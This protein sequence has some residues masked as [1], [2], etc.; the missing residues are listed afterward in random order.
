MISETKH[1]KLIVGI[2]YGTTYSGISFA[3]SSATDFKDIVS[4]T[5]Y[6]DSC[7]HTAEH[8]EKAP[9]TIAFADENVELLR[10]VWG[11]QVKPRLRSCAWTKLLLDESAQSSYDD[12]NIYH[13]TEAGLMRLPSGRTAE[14]VTA[15][16]F[17]G[18][19]TMFE[20]TTTSMFS[21]VG[22][23][24]LAVEFW[25]TVPASWSERAKLLTK[26]AALRAG[27]GARAGDRIMLISEPEAAA[28]YVLKSG[29]H[30]LQSFVQPKTG[31]MV[32]D[33]GGG[34]VDITTY[35]VTQT[36]PTV[37]LRETVVA[38]K[39]GSSYI[40]RNLHQ[41]LAKRFG[42]AFTSL[43]MD[44][45]GPGSAF[46]DR[47]EAIKKD[48]SGEQP[49]SRL[50]HM[51]YLR[52]P[53]LHQTPETNAYYDNRTSSVLLTH[54][55][56]QL[57]FDPVIASILKL[58]ENQLSAAAKFS[59]PPVS[60]I[61]LVGGFGLSP[62]LRKAISQW[63]AK[64]SIAL[65]T[66]MS[67][68]P[69]ASEIINIH[70]ND[71]SLKVYKEI[72]TKSPVLLARYENSQWMSGD[73]IQL[74]DISCAAGHVVVHYL[75]TDQY[76]PIDDQSTSSEL[77]KAE[78]LDAALT[79]ALQVYR[80]ATKYQLPRL[81]ELASERAKQM[82]A[83]LDLLALLQIVEGEFPGIGFIDDWIATY[84]ATRIRSEFQAL[85]HESATLLL[86]DIGRIESLNGI[87]I[88]CMLQLWREKMHLFDDS[89]AEDSPSTISN[90]DVCETSADRSECFTLESAEFS[91][92]SDAVAL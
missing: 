92:G 13:S 24:E 34:T 68:G 70:F 23:D 4:W 36:E 19:Y 6:P 74:D 67:G 91:D 78:Q 55:D 56:V 22:A 44:F 71:G 47:F 66:P 49:T 9:S 80:S 28:H 83:E 14:D 82:F 38:G 33:C 39:C 76:E 12:P 69:Y 11:Y 84:L 18:L 90:V 86:N 42:D 75:F 40:D 63:C 43:G 46:M 54:D 64:R 57:L 58:I 8:N 65:T 53:T 60:A 48:F 16:Y 50:P 7:Q 89:A 85:T 17:K 61:V 30:R 72:L 27:F 35:E 26:R 81:S 41:L 32:C 45:I 52:M 20:E 77:S 79:T 62:C 37:K 25:L 87:V 21:R 3:S 73:G 29:I 15:A 88:K 31:V 51:L 5:K 1:Q 59:A 2:D 10:D